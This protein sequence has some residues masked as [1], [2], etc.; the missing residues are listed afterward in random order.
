MPTYP[1]GGEIIDS[2]G[3]RS[4]SWVAYLSIMIMR[5]CDLIKFYP[6]LPSLVQ[7]LEYDAGLPPHRRHQIWFFEISIAGLVLFLIP[8]LPLEGYPIR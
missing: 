6:P 8:L 2:Y 7:S 1:G 4:T 3:T 5:A